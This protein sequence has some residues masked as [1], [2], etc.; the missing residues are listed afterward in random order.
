MTEAALGESELDEPGQGRARKFRAQ[1][2]EAWARLARDEGKQP[3]AWAGA[4]AADLN[5]AARKS[6][7]L[8]VSAIATHRATIRDGEDYDRRLWSALTRI[9]LDPRAPAA[10][11][12][13]LDRDGEALAWAGASAAEMNDA[14]RAA[15][16][17]LV[18][19]IT[20]HR[21]ATETVT[22]ADRRL[23]RMLAVVNLDPDDYPI[24]SR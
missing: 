1:C 3:L 21:A 8:L 24:P 15:G 4:G 5:P 11:R 19:A 22:D 18:S 6:I 2:L 13:D 7:A 10:L 20:A 14:G 16:A 23:W 17:V 12:R 9:G